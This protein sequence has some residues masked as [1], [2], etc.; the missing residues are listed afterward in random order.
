[1]KGIKRLNII[2]SLI[3]LMSAYTSQVAMADSVEVIIEGVEEDMLENVRA[4]LSLP[5]GIVQDGKVNQLWLDRF[6]DQAEEKAMNA[7]KPFGYYSARVSTSLDKTDEGEYRLRVK[8]ETGEPVRV[9]DVSVGLEGPGKEEPSLVEMASFFPVTTGEVLHQM[10]YENAK[11]AIKSRAIDLGYLDAEY[12]IHEILISVAEKTAD[13]SLVLDTGQK[14]RFGE[15]TFTGG[16]DYPDRYLRRFIDFR[17]GEVFSY[18]KLG[19]T[20]LN[21]INSDRFNS[22][23]VSPKREKAEDHYVPV[24]VQL[25]QAPSR[26]LRPGIGYGTDTGVRLSVK[27]RDLNVFGRGREFNSELNLSQKLSGLSLG[28]IIPDKGSIDSRTEILLNALD[29]DVDRYESRRISAEVNRTRS[30]RKGRLGT[31]YLNVLLEDFTVGSDQSD[32]FLV[33]PGIRFSQRRYDDVVRPRKGFHYSAEIRGSH[34][35][36]GSDTGFLQTVMDSGAI[37]SLPWDLIFYTR[38]RG[39]VTFQNDALEDLPASLRFFA[40]GDRS[41]RG[42]SFQSLGPRDSEGEV[43]GGKNLLVGSLELEKPLF[44]NWGVAVFYDAGN[45][46]NSLSDINL[47]QGAGIGGRYYTKIGTVRLDIARQVDVEN[48]DFRIHLTVGMGL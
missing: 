2:L 16:E 45:A 26:R 20:Q 11:G 43:V 39:A 14:F 46:F 44:R 25:E 41:V 33:I 18:A 10:E 17:K 27:Y 12:T 3:F 8:I 29:E 38:F 42:Y 6:V 9:R 22:V 35:V 47:F 23:I 4:A 7:L 1:M 24:I 36:L 48:P 15:V 31:V 37:I 21:L 40:G 32:A 28:Y 19:K 13:V 30:F 5:P 34:Q